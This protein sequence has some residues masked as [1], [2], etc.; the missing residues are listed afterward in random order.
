[1][2]KYKSLCKKGYSEYKAFAIVE[3]ELSEVFEKQ[4]DDMRILRGAALAEYGDSY[5]D[6]AQRVAELESKLK[7]ERFVRDIPK[8]ERNQDYVGPNEEGRSR[9]EDVIM[10]AGRKGEEY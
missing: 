1:M 8:F 6:R 10:E 7:L 3:K 4:R 9:V 2:R 5:L